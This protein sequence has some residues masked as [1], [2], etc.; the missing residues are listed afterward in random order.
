M[1]HNTGK[2]ELVNTPAGPR[3]K[4]SVH[5]I[6][7]GGVIL[8]EKGRISIQVCKTIKNLQGEHNVDLS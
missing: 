7:P 3:P 2:E 6:K 8:E 1:S 5:A 4:N